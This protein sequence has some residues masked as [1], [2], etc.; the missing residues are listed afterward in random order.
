M[1]CIV[2]CCVLEPAHLL[3]LF[4]SES[5]ELN[6]HLDV[7]P[8]HPL[9]ASLGEDL[10][11][12]GATRKAVHSMTARNT[13]D[14]RVR[15]L[16]VVIARQIQNDPHWAE[17]VFATKIKNL[18]LALGRRSVG[19]PFGDGRRIDQAC[20][21]GLGVG[22]APAVI[23]GATDPKIAAGLTDMADL[24]CIAQNPQLALNLPF[25]LDHKHLL[26][27]NLGRLKKMSRE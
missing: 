25:V 23:T 9:L 6:I 3:T 26:L 16:D 18:F 19:M 21:S 13:R 8:G 11:H 17:V 24:F 1:R 5:Q 7:M 27:P 20:F 2:D 15:H 4:T 10:A 14:R 22:F 12:P